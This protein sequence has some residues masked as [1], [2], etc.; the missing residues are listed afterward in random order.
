MCADATNRREIF[1]KICNKKRNNTKKVYNM[2]KF[3]EFLVLSC[4][5]GAKQI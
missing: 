3:S 5:E 2:H 1:V 4:A